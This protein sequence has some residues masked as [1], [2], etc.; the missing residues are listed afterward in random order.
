M[1]AFTSSASTYSCIRFWRFGVA[2]SICLGITPSRS[3]AA[4]DCSGRFCYHTD[5]EVALIRGEGAANE[6]LVA[7][8]PYLHIATPAATFL[9]I[10]SIYT[11]DIFTSTTRDSDTRQ[12]GTLLLDY[13][14]IG[15]RTGSYSE[16]NA[17]GVGFEVL[18]A[19]AERLPVVRRLRM[20][21]PLSALSVGI[22]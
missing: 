11:K 21:P 20:S 22:W 6:Q 12:A 17:P 8:A 18:R 4:G 10:V 1:M 16:E 2:P 7:K 3:A 19:F 5:L 14:P 13:Q 9:R 15:R